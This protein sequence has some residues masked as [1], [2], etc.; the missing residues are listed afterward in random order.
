VGGK[1]PEKWRKNYASKT[2]RRTDTG[3]SSTQARFYEVGSSADPHVG[4]DGVG[5]DFASYRLGAGK[6]F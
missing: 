6:L 2:D 3:T 1:Q 5:S 4:D